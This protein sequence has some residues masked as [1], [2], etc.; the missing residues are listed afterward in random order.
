MKLAHG[1]RANQS[2]LEV[3]MAKQGVCKVQNSRHMVVTQVGRLSFPNLFTP[4]AFQDKPNEPKY[5]SCHL[6]FD[7][8]DELKMDWNGK[9]TKTPSL[10]KAI[11][12][13]KEDQWGPKENW[14]KFTYPVIFNGDDERN[15]DGEIRDG[16]EGKVYIRLKSGE[17]YP[18]KVVLANGAP[19]TEQDVYGGCYVQA[20]IL[21]RPYLLPKPGVSLRLLGIRK[22]KDGEKFGAGADLFEYEEIDELENDD[23]SDDNEGGDDD[24]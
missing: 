15:K 9:R 17:K 8:I 1:G 24:F 16:Y 13:V 4:K 12:Y 2:H 11:R 7:S 10:L 3:E 14:P 19:A 5:F 20:Q 18:P 23:W 21:V 22:V 6:I